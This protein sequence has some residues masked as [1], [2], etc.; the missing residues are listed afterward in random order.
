M[1]IVDLTLKFMF[2]FTYYKTF[3]IIDEKQYYEK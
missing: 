3:I 1:K 2:D